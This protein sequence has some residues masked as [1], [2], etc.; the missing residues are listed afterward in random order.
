M[1]WKLPTELDLCKGGSCRSSSKGRG[2]AY[3]NA[4]AGR[5]RRNRTMSECDRLRCLR[6]LWYCPGYVL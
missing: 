6:R 4:D 5:V 3:G 2:G 1:L